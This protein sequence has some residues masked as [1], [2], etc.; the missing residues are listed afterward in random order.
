MTHASH[1]QPGLAQSLLEQCGHFWM[2]MSE[3]SPDD[4]PGALQALAYLDEVIAAADRAGSMIS[5]ADP[6]WYEVASAVSQLHYVR[7]DYSW[8]GAD[9]PTWTDL[10]A[11]IG[12]AL[13]SAKPS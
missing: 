13:S 8:P 1:E 10:D 7:F 11:A 2:I 4:E 5:A 9:E 12:W 3:L 6:Y